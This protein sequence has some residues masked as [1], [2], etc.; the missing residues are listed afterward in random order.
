MKMY[1]TTDT[2]LK[3]NDFFFLIMC[4]SMSYPLEKNPIQIRRYAFEIFRINFTVE[5]TVRTS[6]YCIYKI[7]RYI[8]IYYTLYPHFS[9]YGKVI[10]IAPRKIVAI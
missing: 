2:G 7:H 4:I 8:A 6:I 1:F 3:I 9:E 5:F 10:N